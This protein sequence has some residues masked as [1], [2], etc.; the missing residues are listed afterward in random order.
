MRF[1]F[2]S[3]R[4]VALNNI[5]GACVLDAEWTIDLPRVGSSSY[6]CPE[7][8]VQTAAGYVRPAEGHRWTV[9]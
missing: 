1:E 5:W 7:Y 9:D 6:P 4:Q 8:K 2:E 3:S